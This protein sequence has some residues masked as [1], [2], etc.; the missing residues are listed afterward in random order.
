MEYK[1]L[2][3]LKAAG[4]PFQEVSQDNVGRSSSC[5][6]CN[7]GVWYFHMPGKPMQKTREKWLL[8]QYKQFKYSFFL[9]ELC[10]IQT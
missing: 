8:D 1:L 7:Q 2:K 3:E 10:L 4:F 5:V 6:M 9:I